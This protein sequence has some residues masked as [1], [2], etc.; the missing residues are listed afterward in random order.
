MTDNFSSNDNYYNKGG[1]NGESKEPRP[2]PPKGQ[3]LDNE[4]EVVIKQLMNECNEL[5]KYIIDICK[6]L[7]INSKQFIS[8][9]NCLEFYAVLTATAENRIK[10]YKQTLVEIEKLISKFD[11]SS[12]CVYGDFDCENC[13][14]LDKNTACP[15]RL[16]KVIKDI[17]NKTTGK[18]MT[19][20]FDLATEVQETGLFDMEAIEHDYAYYPFYDDL[21]RYC[22]SRNSAVNHGITSFDWTGNITKDE[23][24]E[25]FKKKYK[26]YIVNNS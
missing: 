22:K 9:V 6:L 14:D 26:K 3:L 24:I 8:G 23:A 4:Y 20:L 13:S 15:Y 1:L 2:S 7:E 18:Q 11:S 17:I 21:V 5:R 10:R 19:K 16:K 12:G 25:L